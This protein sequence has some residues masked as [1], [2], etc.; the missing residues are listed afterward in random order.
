MIVGR[1]IES[2]GNICFDEELET[3]KIIKGRPQVQN[4]GIIFGFRFSLLDEKP[5]D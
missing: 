1:Q 3:T 5:I 2:A 4:R